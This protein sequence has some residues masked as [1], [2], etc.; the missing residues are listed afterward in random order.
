MVQKYL[1]LFKLLL[2][3]TDEQR[4]AIVQTLS[5][6]QLKAVIEAIYNVLMGTCPISE[7]DKNKL[8]GYKD[9]IYRLVSEGLDHKQKQRLLKKH[10][11][12]LPIVLNPVIQF[13]NHGNG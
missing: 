8:I 7:R 11:S 10:R 12:L 5:A 3:S 4:A 13:L 2:D 9:V 1:P 6:P